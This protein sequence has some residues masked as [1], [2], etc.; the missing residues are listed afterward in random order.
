MCA[1]NLEYKPG[2]G[3]CIWETTLKQHAWIGLI[4]LW[5]IGVN[6][7]NHVRTRD[8]FGNRR[9]QP[10]R[11]LFTKPRQRSAHNF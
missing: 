6:G 2:F 5:V 4:L 8:S 10:P 1:M 3:K 9:E 11:L 7:A